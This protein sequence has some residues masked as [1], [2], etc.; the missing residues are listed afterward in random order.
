MYFA[1]SDLLQLIIAFITCTVV[2]TN[3]IYFSKPFSRCWREVKT[4]RESQGYVNTQLKL[5]IRRYN[6][7]STVTF[8]NTV[9]IKFLQDLERKR[10]KV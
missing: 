9:H 1:F 8:F 2:L 4:L 7:I 6:G 5:T 10:K 3:N